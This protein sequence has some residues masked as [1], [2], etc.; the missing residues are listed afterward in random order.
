MAKRKSIS[1]RHK[2]TPL[3]PSSEGRKKSKEVQRPS[4][5]GKRFSLDQ[6][7]P[8]GRYV[9]GIHSAKE[10]LSVR[11]RA[12]HSV[13]LKKGWEQNLDLKF[14]YDWAQENS[15]PIKIQSVSFFDKI[16]QTHQG[17]CL[18][19]TERP[20]FDWNS[21][22]E[23]SKQCVL[24]LDGLED[25]HNLGAILRTAWL[26]GVK[27]VFVPKKQGSPLTPTVIKVA[28]GAVEHIPVVEEANLASVIKDL[29][30]IGFWTYGLAQ[31]QENHIYNTELS[32]KVCWVVGAEAKGIRLPILRACDLIVSIPQVNEAASYNASVA[33]AIALSQTTAQFLSRKGLC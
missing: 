4:Q 24:I 26:M 1:K 6:E 12:V 33:C 2:D 8:R 7:L 15:V 5:A 20:K 11:P 9:V 25:P 17:L 10:V 32:D 31:N 18:V 28:S 16:C 19:V 23:D 3:R 13:W 29:K 21:L 14:F 22:K 27:A 30:E